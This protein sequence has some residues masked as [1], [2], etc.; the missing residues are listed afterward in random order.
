MIIT[1]T[2]FRIS[3]CGGGTD[4]P[5]WFNKNGGL[6]VGGTVNKF[7]YISARWLPP[8]HD[9]KSR[10]VYNKIETVNDNTKIEHRLVNAIL[11]SM[12]VTDGVEV[13]HAADLPGRSGTGSSSTFAVGCIRAVTSM[14]GDYMNPYSLAKTA[15]SIERDK[16][17]EDGGWQDQVWASH[18]GLST[19]KFRD[20]DFSIQPMNLSCSRVKELESHLLLLYTGVSRISSDVAASYAA[21]LGTRFQ[22]QAAMMKITEQCIDS[23]YASNWQRL[24]HWIDNAWRIKS[25]LSDK[26]STEQISQM[27]SLAR[28]NG[29]WGGKLMGAGGGGCILLVAPPES[30]PGIIEAMTSVGC[31]HIPFEFEFNGS[32]TVYHG[33]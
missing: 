19:I 11:K 18:G 14:C 12:S 29:A 8:F 20:D 15:I 17:R 1:K 28:L 21:S 31:V 16:L 22:E 30:Q 2:P 33:R 23:I 3:L 24:G 6:V 7:S 13:M 26:V 5:E 10:I 27:Y 25:S 9:H 32:Q 4:Y